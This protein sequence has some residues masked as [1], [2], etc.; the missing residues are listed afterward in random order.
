MPAGEVV[1]LGHLVETEVQVDRRHGEFGRVDGAQ[2]KSRKDVAARQQLRGSTDPVHHLRAQAEEPHLQALQVVHA[3]DRL[4]E[5]AG[6]LGRDHAA[7]DAADVVP[8]VDFL[9]QLLAAAEVE[10]GHVLVGRRPEWNRR[11]EL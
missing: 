9:E 4:P 5:P 3:F 7:Q 1:V 2:L 10:P 6:C 11:K 8:G